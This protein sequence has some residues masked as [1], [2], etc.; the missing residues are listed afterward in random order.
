MLA[1]PSIARIHNYCLVE[2]FTVHYMSRIPDHPA[3]VGSYLMWVHTLLSGFYLATN[4]SGLVW[5]GLMFSL[6]N[7]IGLF[8]QE[9]RY[10]LKKLLNLVF[11]PTISYLP[12]IPQVLL[13]AALV[14]Q[15]RGERKQRYLRK[16]AA[17]QLQKQTF[18]QINTNCPEL[19]KACMSTTLSEDEYSK[20][21][22]CWWR[23]NWWERVSKGNM[24]SRHSTK[25][26]NRNL[27]KQDRE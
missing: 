8:G 25:L 23:P 12:S 16:T 17:K 4:T 3:Y 13:Q 15:A 26:V 24:T 6:Q 2:C 1:F 21:L 14:W 18:W 22:I 19:S 10:M 5:F 11:F 9:C 20:R 7:H 27:Q